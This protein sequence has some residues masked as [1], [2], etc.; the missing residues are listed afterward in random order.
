MQSSILKLTDQYG[1]SV[2][3]CHLPP[4][5]ETLCVAD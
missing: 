4:Y 5:Q 3:E 2:L 1:Y